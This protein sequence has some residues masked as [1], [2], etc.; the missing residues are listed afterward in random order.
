MPNTITQKELPEIAAKRGVQTLAV[1]LI[2][3]AIVFGLAPLV[4]AIG[5]AEGWQDFISNWPAWTWEIFKGATVAALTALIA[6]F[7]RR[8]LDH[9]GVE[10]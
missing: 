6:W 5:G 7:Q 2:A 8:Y 1:G 9:D 3:A 10:N 4:A